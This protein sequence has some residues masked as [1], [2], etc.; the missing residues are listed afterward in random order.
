MTGHTDRRTFIQFL[1][2]C[3]LCVTIFGLTGCP[4]P[5]LPTRT[6]FTAAEEK[7][8]REKEQKA[9]WEKQRAE[10]RRIQDERQTEFK[11]LKKWLKTIRDNDDGAESAVAELKTFTDSAI[12]SEGG[13]FNYQKDG[14]TRYPTSRVG[15]LR[16]LAFENETYLLKLSRSEDADIQSTSVAILELAGFGHKFASNE[17]LTSIFL[18]HYL[19]DSR[20]RTVVNTADVLET[21]KWARGKAPLCNVIHELSNRGEAVQH[22][23]PVMKAYR[24]VMPEEGFAFST[25]ERLNAPFREQLLGRYYWNY[26]TEDDPFFEQAEVYQA[27][28]TFEERYG[29]KGRDIRLRRV[30]AGELDA[31][32]KKLGDPT[33]RDALPLL[34]N[35]HWRIQV[36]G[37]QAIEKAA[38][39]DQIGEVVASLAKLEGSESHETAFRAKYA[40]AVLQNANANV[41]EDFVLRSDHRGGDPDRTSFWRSIQ[42]DA[43]WKLVSLYKDI[44]LD[45]TDP[46]TR[47]AAVVKLGELGRIS[48]STIPVLTALLNDDNVDLRKAADDAI[49]KIQKK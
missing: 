35:E 37:I 25:V 19:F 46:K 27:L 16:N 7:A 21:A 31:A 40:I 12:E 24:K 28:P 17:E 45:E 15:V 41:F 47:K 32:T 42:S 11:Q 26:V 5:P 6:E 18:S 2:F 3:I 36:L 43:K 33:W 34:A 39:E 49:Q 10:S 1:R 8:K 4:Q 44:V 38:P 20:V 22:L 29:S 13:G 48:S 23:V 14:Y 30:V 9:K